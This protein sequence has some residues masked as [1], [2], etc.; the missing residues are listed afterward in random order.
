M[1]LIVPTSSVP[2]SDLDSVPEPSGLNLDSKSPSLDI[3]VNE[4]T[5]ALRALGNGVVPL[6]AACAFVEL[7]RRFL[8]SV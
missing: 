1:W 6:Q 7:M 4:R 8:K 3:V 5:G 2:S